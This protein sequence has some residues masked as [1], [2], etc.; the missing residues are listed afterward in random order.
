MD[1]AKI[2]IIVVIVLLIF[3]IAVCLFG[4]LRYYANK[5]HYD[6]R[7]LVA[8]HMFNDIYNN[9]SKRYRLTGKV[10]DV[11]QDILEENPQI[12]NEEIPQERKDFIMV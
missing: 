12:V 10:K 1:L 6:T 2:M 5:E 7:Q 9:K 4:I 3:I 11:P 8:E